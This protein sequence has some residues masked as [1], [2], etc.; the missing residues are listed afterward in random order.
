[1]RGKLDLA[2]EDLGEQRLKNIAWPV[3][4]YR[5]QLGREMAPPRPASALPDKPSI[6]VLPFTNMSGDPEQEYFSDGM[7]EDIITEL[8]RWNELRVLSRHSSFRYRGKA[9][10]LQQVGRE[11][12]VRYVVAGS[13]RRMQERLRMTVQLI[14]VSSGSHIWAEHYDRDFKD[15]FVVQEDVVRTMVGTLVGR[16]QAVD[17]SIAKRKP[18]LSLDA[19]DCV[20]RGNAVPWSEPD[21]NPEAAG[22]YEKAITLDPNY[23]LAHALLALELE[24][25]WEYDDSGSSALLDRAF[26]LAK[27]AVQLAENESMGH[28]VLGRVHL[29]RRSFDLAETYYR[30]AIEMNPNN[31]TH[32]ADIGDL[33]TV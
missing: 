24:T 33:L 19:Y 18:P 13:V 2:F 20:L 3:R 22:W 14:D 4:I 27:K 15:I 12:G 25:R 6:A 5:A 11:L 29:Q 7:T 26:D 32:M 9:A 17:A 31:P 21:L 16:V 1:V 23:G 8:S 10:D 30:R 28:F